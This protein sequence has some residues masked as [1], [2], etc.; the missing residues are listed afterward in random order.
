MIQVICGE[1]S[2]RS[3]AYFNQIVDDY[4][5]KNYEIHRIAASELID[6]VQKNEQTTSLFSSQLIYTITNLSSCV[7]RLKAKSSF[8]P[9]EKIGKQKDIIVIDWED[10]KSAREFTMHFATVIKECKP[11]KSIFHLLDSL[12]PNNIQ[13]AQ[14]LLRE[15]CIQQ[16]AMFVFT[17]IAR[18]MHALLL[19]KHSLFSSRVQSWQKAKLL[20]QVQFWKG[21]NIE[22]CIESLFRIDVALKT[23]STPLQLVESLEILMVHYL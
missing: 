18:H 23:G 15:L 6:I 19:A 20:K 13:T 11:S 2:V 16:D 1:D 10:G 8:L 7:G 5:K 9:Y 14:L 12:Y 17:M 3:L 21:N 22:Y 4:R